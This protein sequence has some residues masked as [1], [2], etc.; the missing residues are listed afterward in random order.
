MSAFKDDT[1]Y[2]NST[3][4]FHLQRERI[5]KIFD[6][7]I[8]K[9]RLLAHLPTVVENDGEILHKFLSE[10]E[11]DFVT[12]VCQEQQPF[13]R[14]MVQNRSDLTLICNMLERINMHDP[15]KGTTYTSKKSR[16]FSGLEH[17]DTHVAYALDIVFKS[18]PLVEYMK[19]LEDKSDSLM[20]TFIDSMVKLKKIVEERLSVS[21]SEEIKRENDLKTA[22]RS[23]MMLSDLIQELEELLEKQ[24]QELGR[25][26][27]RKEEIL[28]ELAEK[29]ETLKEKSRKD[30]NRVVYDTEIVMMKDYNKSVELQA[31]L[32]E[33]AK[34]ATEQYNSLLEDHLHQEKLL[35][36]KR[37][38]V[39]TQL[40]SWVAKYDNDIG[41][42]QAEYDEL[43]EIYQKEK[44]EL[45]ELQEKFED[46]A[47][48]YHIL[49]REKE[50]EE[51]R[52][53][54]EKAWIFLQNRS[55]RRIQRA[56]R[57]YRARKL[58]RKKGRKS[59]KKGGS[60]GKKEKKGPKDK[61]KKKKEE[62]KPV[63][64]AD[65]DPNALLEGKY[66]ESILGEM[67][68]TEGFDKKDVMVDLI[69]D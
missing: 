31:E 68:S 53:Y 16:M 3:Y 11:A 39:E 69:N 67:K 23:S 47:E 62:T 9:L 21:A 59:K 5:N 40:A 10:T 56:W 19:S 49:M 61:K 45:D 34:G 1:E 14:E 22:Y 28:R 20:N 64:K 54:E 32:S 65:Q 18:K 41:E 36:A 35:R 7:T 57:A 2:E 58:A 46:Q 30:I 8:Q 24:R 55:A 38:K 43:D 42:K 48:E 50:E 44:S 15:K 66:R 17:F 26:H 51:Q 63:L 60:A 4:E 13:S 6:E 37:L 33:D 25:E 52:I 29:I 27:D 12:L